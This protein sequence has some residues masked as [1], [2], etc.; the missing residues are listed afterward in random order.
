MTHALARVQRYRRRQVPMPIAVWS[1]STAT[2]ER[3][4]GGFDGHRQH[5]GIEG[6]R[7]HVTNGRAAMHR[8]KHRLGRDLPVG[9][10]HT[11]FHATAHVRVGVADVELTTGNV[12][13]TAIQSDALGEPGNGVL[14]SCCRRR[15]ERG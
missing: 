10:R 4:G 11:R 14:G 15:D 8:V 7:R 5:I 9:L 1:R 13:L 3:H 12:V 6:Q 2:F